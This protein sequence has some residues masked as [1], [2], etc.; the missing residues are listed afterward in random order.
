MQKCVLNVV[1]LK[2]TTVLAKETKISI[3]PN[4][5]I[6]INMSCPIC[7][8]KNTTQYRSLGIFNLN[9]IH[10]NNCNFNEDF[11]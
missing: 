6:W 5:K 7:K 2:I 11:Q 9:A 1:V 3:Y 8:S 4:K 10:C